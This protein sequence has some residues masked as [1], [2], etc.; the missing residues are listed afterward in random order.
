MFEGSREDYRVVKEHGCRPL[1]GGRWKEIISYK[2]GNKVGKSLRPGKG[3]E[4]GRITV[5]RG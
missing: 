2:D 4:E 5:L 1:L 3:K